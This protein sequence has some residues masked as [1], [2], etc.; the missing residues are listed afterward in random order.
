MYYIEIHSVEGIKEYFDNGGD[1]NEVIDGIPLFTT[2]VEMYLR[3]PVFKECI[4]LFIDQGLVFEDKALLAV[5]SDDAEILKEELG[6]NKNIVNKRYSIFNNTFTSLENSTLLHYCAEYNHPECAKVLVAHGADVNAQA[7]LDG[8]GFGGHT[9]IFHAVAQHNNNS[10][11]MLHFLLEN[12]AD[13]LHSI[14]GLIWGKGYEWETFI[15]ALN[16]LSYAM[17]GLLPQIHRDPEM[18]A[19]NISMLLKYAYGID[20]ELPNVPNVYLNS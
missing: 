6:K 1:P 20:Y 8:N 14:K 19:G 10:I 12:G 9:P 16:P 5:L 17:M 7:G 15:P 4:K 2:M 13:P 3:S 11:D 18:I